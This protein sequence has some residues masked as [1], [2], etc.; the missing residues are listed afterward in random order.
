MGFL[1][2][3]CRYVLTDGTKREDHGELRSLGEKSAQ[4]VTGSISWKAPDGQVNYFT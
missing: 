2:H 3:L 4:V 1:Y